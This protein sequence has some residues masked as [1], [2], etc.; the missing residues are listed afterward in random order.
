MRTGYIVAS[1]LLALLLVYAAGRKL[2][3]RPDVVASYAR[4]G[5]PEHRLGVL[6]MLL[7]AG[8]IGIVAGIFVAAIGIAAA[9]CLVVYFALA[10]VAHVRH[11]D[12]ANLPTPMVMLVL[13]VVVLVLRL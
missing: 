9:L 8:A 2:S 6:A 10:I 1:A 5:V 3:H 11:E 13:S 12:L 7:L 4:V